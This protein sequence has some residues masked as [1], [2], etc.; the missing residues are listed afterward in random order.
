MALLQQAGGFLIDL[1][2]TIIEGGQLIPGAAEALKA[3]TRKEIPY[4]VVTNTTSKPRSAILTHMSA[5]GIDLRP[6]QLITAPIIGRDYL[7][8]EGITRCFP[9]LK[10]SL[11]EDLAMIEFVEASPQAFHGCQDPEEGRSRRNPV[12]HRDT[13]LA[14]F[15]KKNQVDL[16]SACSVPL[17]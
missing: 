15:G 2:G 3:L 5:L 11:L 4:R 8:R 13:E 17:W 7:L 1:D 10:A 12:Y 14:E 6:A 16:F 9:L